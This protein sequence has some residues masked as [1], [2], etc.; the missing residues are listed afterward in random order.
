MKKKNVRVAIGDARLSLLNTPAAI[1]DLLIVDAF[2]GDAIPVHLINKDVV[3]L[4]RHH[5]TPQGG[6]LFHIPSRYFNLE[7]VLA[8]IAKDVGANVAVKEAVQDGITLRTFWAV[9]TWDEDRFIRLIATN[10]WR[11]LSVENQKNLRT[12]SDNYS[13][14]LP[15]LQFDQ[16]WSSLKHYKP[17]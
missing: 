10:G 15:I 13:T 1:Y 9:M 3:Q 5:L 7:P 8:A 11:P 2:G 17:F 12:W 14:V 6:I 4:Y 16:L